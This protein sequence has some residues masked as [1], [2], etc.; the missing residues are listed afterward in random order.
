MAESFGTKIPKKDLESL[1]DPKGFLRED[2]KKNYM[3]ESVD[4]SK[5]TKPKI[6]LSVDIRGD[7]KK[8]MREY[9]FDELKV[10]DKQVAGEDFFDRDKKLCN[11]NGKD[12]KGFKAKGPE[13]TRY[14][15]WERNGRCFD[16]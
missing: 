6:N 12:E 10:D 7:N 11:T 16:F 15:D 5:E 3:D 1:M 14:G 9:K 4:Q 2:E 13:P 8:K